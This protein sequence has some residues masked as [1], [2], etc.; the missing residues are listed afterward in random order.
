MS[1]E[2][3]KLKLAGKGIVVLWVMLIL[4]IAFGCY[5]WYWM[6][7]NNDTGNVL[8]ECRIYALERDIYNADLCLDEARAR[9]D[10]TD[11]WCPY[12]NWFGD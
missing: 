6:S 4:S 5:N 12:L 7:Y 11:K 3:Y 10:K 8:Q 9:L 2:E 1:T